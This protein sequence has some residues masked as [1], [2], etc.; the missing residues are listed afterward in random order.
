M[1][2]PMKFEAQGESKSGIASSWKSWSGE[3]PPI[4]CAIPVEFSGPGN[5]YSPE[6]LFSLSLLSCM[7]AMFKVYCEKSKISFQDLKAK[8][9]LTMDLNT[10][11]NV[12]VFTHADV[13]ITVK[14]ASDPGKA[15]ELL[16]RA[17]K[18]CPVSNSIKTGKTFHFTF[19]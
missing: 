11:E 13:T 12:L 2:F 1:K 15:R 10:S 3:L 14:G 18:D 4:P 8:V 6:D 19:D 7:V 16:E 9:M 17:V 5:A